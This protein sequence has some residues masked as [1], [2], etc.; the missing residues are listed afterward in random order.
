[1][2]A[3]YIPNT[4]VSKGAQSAGWLFGA[5]VLQWANSGLAG[6]SKTNSLSQNQKGSGWTADLY[7]G[8]QSG[9]D[10][11]ACYIPV[12]ELPLTQLDNMQWS[13]YQTNTETMGL[14]CVIWVHD[15][16]DFDKRAEITQVGGV[17][18][19]RPGTELKCIEYQRSNQ[20]Q[21]PL[22]HRRR[23]E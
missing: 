3:R 23:T 11:A 5:P 10:W 19:H 13:W 1:M 22:H 4:I 16:D 2:K 12:N 9:D 8:A 15:P 17:A 14:G 18:G 7:G 6:W 21:K 20:M